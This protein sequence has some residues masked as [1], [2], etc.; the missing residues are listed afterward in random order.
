MLEPLR[1]ER[2]VRLS[3][4]VA[5]RGGPAPFAERHVVLAPPGAGNIGDQ[6]LTE[7]F[8]ESVSGPVTVL[9]RSIRDVAVPAHLAHRM[10]ILPVPALV[11]GTFLGHGRDARAL[12]RALEGA[13]SFSVLGAD[14]MDG[15]YVPRASVNRA[16]V[17]GRV[18]ELGWDARVIGFSWNAAPHPAAVAALRRAAD[19]GVRLYV[20]DPRSAAR[21]RADGLEVRDSADI[22]FS[23][24]TVDDDAPVRIAGALDGGPFALVNASGLVGD[25][26]DAYR[27]VVKRLR[28]AELGVLLVPHVSRHGAD[29]LPLAHALADAFRHD[30]GVVLVPRLLSPA[31]IRGLAARAHL[32]VTGR[33]HLAVMALMA[34]TPAVTVATQGKVE[35]LMELFGTPELVVDPHGD[36]AADLR[37]AVDG[38][39]GAADTLAARIAAALPEVARLSARNVEGLSG[40]PAAREETA[41]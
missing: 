39:L 24:R 6:A 25:R 5:L 1:S 22:V 27:A 33:M 18:A 29:D 38:V 37:G 41:A 40:A 26:T 16:V 13:A 7:A 32:A 17:A 12:S 14:I 10:E 4:A 3:D 15:A 19:S 2:L 23:A 11:Y 35:G 34:A 21:A 30:P 28:A 9:T 31:E 8:A 36:F 20:R